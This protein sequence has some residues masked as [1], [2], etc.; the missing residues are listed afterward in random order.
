MKTLRIT[1]LPELDYTS[2]EAMNTL[3]TNL[4]FAGENIR[5]IMLTS[6]RPHEGKSY[7]SI[8]LMR[9]MA[10]L[11]K[12]VVLVDAD[13]RKSILVGRYGIKGSGAALGL[14]HYLA[15]MCPGEDIVYRTNIKNASIILAGQDVIN[16]L[17]LFNSPKLAELLNWLAREYDAVLIDT[18]P[19][20]ALI[21]T[22]QIA[23][24]CEGALFVVT[25]HEISR[26]E[27]KE[28]RKQIEI[29]GCPV[30]GAVLNKV[31]FRKAGYRKGYYY[32]KY[33]TYYGHDESS[34]RNWFGRKKVTG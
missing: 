12:R 14:A 2:N 31:E 7:I 29:T 8:N 3:C 33:Q 9:S 20:G 34:R 30:L 15:G 13:L 10:N 27:L 11:G 24:N 18:P 5:K 23:R 16:S 17:P 6:C 26:R 25:T 32:S 28:A 19:I 1:R 21:D 22:A 4:S